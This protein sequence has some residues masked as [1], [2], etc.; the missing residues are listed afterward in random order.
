MA[1]KTKTIVRKKPTKKPSIKSKYLNKDNSLKANFRK[2]R[3]LP[4][5]ELKSLE[6]SLMKDVK[7]SLKDF[8]KNGVKVNKSITKLSAGT[9]SS[10]II[11]NIYR[12]SN[13]LSSDSG[14]Y[15]KYSKKQAKTRKKI[16][17]RIGYKFKDEA[18]FIEFGNF[19]N[20]MKKRAGDMW[21][22]QSMNA[23]ELFA[24][25]KRLNLDTNVLKKNRK[26]WLEQVEN[27]KQIKKP[28][29][30][31]TKP[32]SYTKKLHLPTIKEFNKRMKA[33]KSGKVGK[34]RYYEYGG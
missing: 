16:E 17:K 23:G 25:A 6:K 20:D 33:T 21:S 2:I 24:E 29:P 19:M 12:M 13:W 10:S 9:N 4:V 26:Y 14:S 5:K 31:E 27:L 32:S 28:L 15:S 8:D 34:S 3:T 11:A 30:T 22:F 18:E 7:K 1:R